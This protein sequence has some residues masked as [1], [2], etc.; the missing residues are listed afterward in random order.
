M[1]VVMLQQNLISDARCKEQNENLIGIAECLIGWH[2]DY[3]MLEDNR[4]GIDVY[5]KSLLR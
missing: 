4:V 3:A 2:N 1:W 5:Q